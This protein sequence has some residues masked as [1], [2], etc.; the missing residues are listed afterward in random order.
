MWWVAV[1]VLGA[2]TTQPM[3]RARRWPNH[4]KETDT[5]F[6]ELERRAAALEEKNAGLEA[7]LGE[8]TRRLKLIEEAKQT[9]NPPP[10]ASTP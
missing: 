2:C 9:A 8:L 4:R 10:N 3:E 6:A 1:L 5:R 7:S